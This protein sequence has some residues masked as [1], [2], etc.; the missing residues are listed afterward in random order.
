MKYKN[1]VKTVFCLI[2]IFNLVFSIP[3]FTSIL[4]LQQNSGPMPQKIMFDES[5][6]QGD[7]NR[8]IISFQEGTDLTQATRI[9]REICKDE[10][11]P[12][13][14]EFISALCCEVSREELSKIATLNIVQKIFID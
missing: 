6:F 2:F 5:L 4:L 3:I 12:L 13:S 7:R 8:V 1:A 9:I 10:Q 14:F 11:E